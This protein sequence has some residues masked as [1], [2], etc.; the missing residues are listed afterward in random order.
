MYFAIHRDGV[1][2]TIWSS[3]GL[4]LPSSGN[5]GA[6]DDHINIKLQSDG[7]G[8]YAVTKTSNEGPSEPLI[9]LLSCRS[10]CSTPASWRATTVYRADERHTRA[11][12]LLDT[13]NRKINIFT[14][15]TETGG[16]LCRNWRSRL[17]FGCPAGTCH[18]REVRV[19]AGLH[20]VSR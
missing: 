13:T 18:A 2:T 20:L 17:Y 8:V 9:V 14:A 12:L 4:Y 7:V 3:F 19:P 11:I 16:G 5:P 6:A 10:G 15:T 1:P